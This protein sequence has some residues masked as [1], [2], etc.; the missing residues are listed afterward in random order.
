VK[1][2]GRRYCIGI[3]GGGFAGMA[4]ARMTCRVA[5]VRTVLYDAKEESEFLPLLPDIVGGRVDAGLAAAPIRAASDR[6]G[7]EF[8]NRRVERVD[9]E[10]R[11]VVAGD[12]EVRHDALIVASGARTDDHDRADVSRHALKLNSIADAAKLAAAFTRTTCGNVPGY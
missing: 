10:G 3:V 12:R 1:D 11:S 2:T 5:G 6:L 8:V 4:A 9:C 7:F